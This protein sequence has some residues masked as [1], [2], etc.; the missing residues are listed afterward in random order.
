MKV[1]YLGPPKLTFGYQ[2]AKKFAANKNHVELISFSSHQ[3]VC[4]AIIKK[5][6]DVG[7]VAIENSIDGIVNENIRI[8]DRL[9][10]GRN[11]LICG[12]IELPISLFFLRRADA[13]GLPTQLTAHEKAKGQSSRKV[14]KFLEANKISDFTPAKSNGAAVQ[15]AKNDP[16]V[17]AIGLAEA[18]EI[19]NLALVEPESIT[20]GDKNYTRFWALSLKD[21]K[22]T[23]KDKTCFLLNSD[24]P[25]PGG[26]AKVLAEFAAEKINLWLIAPVS[27]EGRTWEYSFLL[28]FEGNFDDPRM[29]RA[30]NAACGCGG[31]MD[32]LIRLGSYPIGTTVR[33]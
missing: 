32:G 30:Y 5:E 27:I 19:C 26:V 10:R 31:A 8:I 3:E 23:K 9:H 2:A 16:S 22:P 15:A 4:L 13:Q 1:G 6:I 28:E 21:A 12:E 11:L 29:E 25:V 7:I 33:R 18:A 17:V 14:A 20:D 24:Q